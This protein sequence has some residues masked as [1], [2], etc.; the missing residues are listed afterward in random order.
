[1]HS[2]YFYNLFVAASITRQGRS[3]ISSAILLFEGLLSNN[4]L[5]SSL[6]D[7]VSFIH[8]VCSEERKYSDD[9]LDSNIT[10]EECYFKLLT[11]WVS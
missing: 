8:N 3:S 1:M 6:D 10:M 5:F 9:I 11:N 7:I 2:S 4:V